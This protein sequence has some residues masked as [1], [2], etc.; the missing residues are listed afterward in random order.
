MAIC[1]KKT[2]ACYSLFVP[3]GPQ[4]SYYIENHQNDSATVIGDD[5][6]GDVCTGEAYKWYQEQFS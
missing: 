4:I 1:L 6:I 3:V 2:K 5:E